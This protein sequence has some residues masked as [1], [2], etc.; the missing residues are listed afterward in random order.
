MW[1]FHS[2]SQPIKYWKDWKYIEMWTAVEILFMGDI[3]HHLLSLIHCKT[4]NIQIIFSEYSSY[5]LVQDFFHHQYHP[6]VNTDTHTHMFKCRVQKISAHGAAETRSV[7]TFQLLINLELFV[8]LFWYNQPL[9]T[10]SFHYEIASEAILY[11][12]ITYNY[13]A[14]GLRSSPDMYLDR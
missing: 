14:S 11:R 10:G 9:S 1:R 3:P 4:W 2:G 8:S 7:V 5:Q 13:S 6:V 12:S